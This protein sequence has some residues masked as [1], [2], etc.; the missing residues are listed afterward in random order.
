[1]AEGVAEGLAAALGQAVE[2]MEAQ[3][4]SLLGASHLAAQLALRFEAPKLAVW[5]VAVVAATGSRSSDL[6]GC[7][8]FTS[9]LH[10]DFR[11]GLAELLAT[12][13]GNLVSVFC[14]SF[15][16]HISSLSLF[17]HK[18]AR[19]CCFASEASDH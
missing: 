11:I 14:P 5:S 13:L 16:G 9:D 18:C 6:Q 2:G 19:R 10:F 1:M 15:G 4:L 12:S 7:E 8:D 17:S 3:M